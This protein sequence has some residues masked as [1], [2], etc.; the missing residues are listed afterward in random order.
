MNKGELVEAMARH[1]GSSKAEAERSLEAFTGCVAAGLKLKGEV[2]IVGFGTFRI[3][4]R[5]ARTGRNPKT[6]EA[7]EIGP[8]KSVA[9]RPGKALRDVI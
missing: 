8:T 7:M 9:F 4:R 6:G 3:S 5:A 2:G 1:M